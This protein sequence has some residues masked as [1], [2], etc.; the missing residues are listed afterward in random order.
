MA[1]E[2]QMDG[3]NNCSG[4]LAVPVVG[5][6][7]CALRMKRGN[8]MEKIEPLM[9]YDDGQDVSTASGIPKPTK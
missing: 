5:V 2:T 9:K 4:N 1:L 7:P 8:R 3:E 6:T